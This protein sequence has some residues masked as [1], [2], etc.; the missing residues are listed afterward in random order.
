MSRAA[1]MSEHPA[2][3]EQVKPASKAPK[4]GYQP[5][6]ERLLLLLTV[7]LQQQAP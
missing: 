4:R 6:A 7:L 3:V 2:T 1:A 5:L